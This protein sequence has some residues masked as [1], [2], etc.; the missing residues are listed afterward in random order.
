MHYADE[1]I[2]LNKKE[3]I[4]AMIAVNRT[5]EQQKRQWNLHPHI[6]QIQPSQRMQQNIQGKL[7]IKINHVTIANPVTV[8]FI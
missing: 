8:H 7:F 5:R 4:S 3:N 1:I 6:P 2:K